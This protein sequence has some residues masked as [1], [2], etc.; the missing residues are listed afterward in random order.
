MNFGTGG[1]KTQARI[2]GNAPQYPPVL[3]LDSFEL[4]I[5]LTT[6]MAVR[7]DIPY[8]LLARAD[9]IVV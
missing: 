5:N 8:A 6:A 4:V 1:Q 3:L 2:F 9:E 7:P